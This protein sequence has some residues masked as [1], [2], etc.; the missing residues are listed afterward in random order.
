M[1]SGL[2]VIG[3]ILGVMLTAIRLVIEKLGTAFIIG[4]LA[5]AALGLR[6]FHWTWNHLPAACF[7]STTLN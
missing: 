1:L 3:N 7:F 4:C 5:A 6:R 2:A